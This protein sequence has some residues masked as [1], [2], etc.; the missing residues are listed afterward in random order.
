[1]PLKTDIVVVNEFS[2]PLPGGKGSRG[3]RRGRM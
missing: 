1:M 2:V 3:G